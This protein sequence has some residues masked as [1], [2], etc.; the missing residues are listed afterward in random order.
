MQMPKSGRFDEGNWGGKFNPVQFDILRRQMIRR[1]NLIFQPYTHYSMNPVRPVPLIT[2]KVNCMYEAALSEDP[3][4]I[5]IRDAIKRAHL[6]PT[7]KYDEPQT[8]S[9]EYGWMTCPLI[10]RDPKDRRFHHPRVFSE[11]S[12]HKDLEWQFG[13]V[14]G[15]THEKSEPTEGGASAP[16][17][18]P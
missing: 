13:I 8:E 14:R 16:V 12:R 4:D 17:A 11:H 2:G 7:H 10:D 18:D 1:E 9:Q 6:Q 15:S 5:E 3:P